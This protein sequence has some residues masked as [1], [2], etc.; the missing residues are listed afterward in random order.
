ML[1]SAGVNCD[2]LSK[3]LF[4]LAKQISRARLVFR[5][6][7]QLSMLN[8]IIHIFKKI[9][10]LQNFL[11]CSSTQKKNDE[12]I[13]DVLLSSFITLFYTI[14]SF[15]ELIAWLSE[16]KLLKFNAAKWFHY[17]LLLWMGALASSAFKTIKRLPQ[18]GWRQWVV[19]IGQLADFI[20]ASSMVP[21][22]ISRRI[23]YMIMSPLQSMALSAALSFIASS[24][25][26][27]RLF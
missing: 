4:A 26:L 3:N 17:S 5:Q 19:L 20:S 10:K 18:A 22:S 15:V 7:G 25:S 24:I 12:D 16:A 27:Y 14:N 23:L 11:L 21:N 13:G 9:N 6:L 1:V 2:E 8:Q